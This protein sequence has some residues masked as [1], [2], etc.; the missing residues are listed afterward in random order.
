VAC[1]ELAGVL[2]ANGPNWDVVFQER[3]GG[4]A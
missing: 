1:L 4:A 3:L 2:D